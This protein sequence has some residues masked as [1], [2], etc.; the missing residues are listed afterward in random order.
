M[1]PCDWYTT[2]HKNPYLKSS[3]G[4]FPEI[5]SRFKE[6]AANPTLSLNASRPNLLHPFSQGVLSNEKHQKFF[7]DT[8]SSLPIE[9]WLEGAPT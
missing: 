7:D 6:L 9:T 4:I 5:G 8:A 3:E 2:I 1:L